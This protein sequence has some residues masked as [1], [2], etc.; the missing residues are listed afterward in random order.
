MNLKELHERQGWTLNQKID[1][2][3]GVIDQFITRLGKDKVYLA[4][5]GGKDSTVLMHLCEVI[6]KDM[7]CVFV[8]TGCESESVVK[9]VRQCKEEGHNIIT[10]RPRMTPRQVWSEYGFPLLSK[11]ICYMVYQV[12]SNPNCASSKK[13]QSLYWNGRKNFFKIADKWMYLIDEPYD[14]SNKCCDI[15]KKE[16]SHRYEEETGRMPILGIM[17]SESSMRETEY[18]KRGSCN[19]F[20]QK[21]KSISH[22]L[23]IWVE[24]DIV[25]FIKLRNIKIADIYHKGAKRTGCV[26]CGFGVQFAQDNRLALLH[27]LY[28]KYY[29]MVMNFT[30]HGVTYREAL[31]KAL[32]V[33]GLELPD[34]K[35]D[36]F[37]LFGL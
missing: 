16:P 25:E 34:E 27:Q 13:F 32:A 24:E 19:V 29:D 1:H 33:E 5:S 31:R 11:N 6:Y 8:N 7:P 2:S 18:V 21:G 23:S 10:L 36:L 26:A 12:R 20:D 22:P 14:I 28:P 17:A 37:G 35:R 3:L 4:F 15:L 30:N 9:F